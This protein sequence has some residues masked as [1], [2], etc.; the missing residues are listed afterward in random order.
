MVL[1]DEAYIEFGGASF[2]PYL[3]Q[4]PNVLLGRTFS[5]L[6]VSRACASAW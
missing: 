5:E 1:I 3:S 4:F 6:T 2:I